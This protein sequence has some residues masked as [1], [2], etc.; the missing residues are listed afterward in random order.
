MKHI[1]VTGFTGNVGHEVALHLK[2]RQAPLRC[3]VR[4]VEKA[5][6]AHGSEFEYVRLDFQH[7][8]T[9]E[10]ALAGIDRVFLMYPPETAFEP[11]HMF[12]RK[13]K[14]MGVRHIVYLSVKDVQYI[15][16]IPHHKN[17][18][19]IRR[20]GIPYTFLRAGYFMQNL[21][22]FLLDELREQ[23]RI[24]VPA[25]KGKTSFVDVRD[26]AEIGAR[27][28][29]EGERHVGCKHVLT[30]DQAMDFFEV[31]Q[32]MTKILGRPIHYA[33]PSAKEFKTY[34]LAKGLPEDYLN[35]VIGL[36][37]VTKIGFAKGIT[38]KY[39]T[40]TGSDPIRLEQ[41]LRDYKHYWEKS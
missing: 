17:E 3:A 14:E 6:H 21:N 28:L 24:Y 38:N 1:L 10:S 15:P 4:D 32:L 26:V 30:G 41:Y 19:A 23:D 18:R 37:L 25:G 35:V 8:E 11:F 20:S 36:H 31:A 13:A 12:I 34:L 5:R 40:L 2:Q 9:F 16:F 27:A 7:P 39:R 33:N 29:T 22:L